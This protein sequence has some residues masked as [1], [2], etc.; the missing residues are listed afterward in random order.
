MIPVVILLSATLSLGPVTTSERSERGP[1]TGLSQVGPAT[2][3]SLSPGKGKNVRIRGYVTEVISPTEFEIED[4]RITRDAGFVLDLQNI[5]PSV[6]FNPQDIRVGVEM[7]I[8]GVFY[9]ASGELQATS[10]TVD[11]EQFKK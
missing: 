11:M 7:E 9:E 3:P 4:Y 2:D 6:T 8:K 1:F 5:D 10:I